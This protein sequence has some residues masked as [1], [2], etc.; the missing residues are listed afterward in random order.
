MWHCV[1]QHGSLV[2]QNDYGAKSLVV[3]K[4]APASQG[5]Q[6]QTLA[7]TGVYMLQVSEWSFS[8]STYIKSLN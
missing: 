7:Q 5:K 8:Y 4:M 3:S 1:R 2:H 6:I